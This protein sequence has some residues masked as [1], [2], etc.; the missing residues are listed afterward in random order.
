MPISTGIDFEALAQA[1][2]RRGKP[3][4]PR[5]DPAAAR[6][7]ERRRLEKR[8]AELKCEGIRLYEPM[9]LGEQFHACNALWR[10]AGGGNRACKSLSTA[11]EAARAL[12][13][14]DPYNKYPKLKCKAWFVGLKLDHIASMYRTLFQPGAFKIIRDEHTKQW[15]SVRWDRN[16]PTRLQEYDD[17]YR[18]KWRDAPPLIPARFIRG[19]SWETTNEVPRSIR[20]Q[21]WDTLWSSALGKPA[22]GDHFNLVV[23]DEEMPNPEF[24][25]EAHR[26]LTRLW[27]TAA[28]RPKGIWSATSQVAN[29]EL[30]ELREKAVNDPESDF[31]RAFTFLPADNPYLSPEARQELYDGFDEEQRLTR[32]FGIPAMSHRSVYP[33]FDPH[34]AN[35]VEPFQIPAEWSIWGVLDPG[36]THC[37]TIFIAIDPD[38]QYHTVYDG[39][40]L[41]HA[42]ADAWAEAVKERQHGTKF[43]GWIC[44]Q[45]RGK[46]RQDAEYSKTVA[47]QYWDA[48]VRA[49]VQVRSTGPGFGMG[50]FFPGSN[51]VDAREKSLQSMMAVRG[52]G[53]FVG[54]AKWRVM[55]GV[56]PELEKQ[57]RRAHTD[58]KNPEKRF[59]DKSQ[60]SDLVEAAEYGAAFDPGYREP[61]AIA[62]VEELNV[63]DIWKSEVSRA[64]RARNRRL[65][66]VA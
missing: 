30:A 34:G 26:G 33:R 29:P 63:Y 40:D 1:L 18:E 4:V 66:G 3:L 36:R 50:G 45:Q 64:K 51:D 22:Q 46:Q 11:A 42:D 28:Q 27:E 49:A 57:I 21:G 55:R 19:I 59:K 9:L 39:F 5:V 58:P 6:R 12:T 56:L 16:N 14:T 20:L 23:F 8:L 15:R 48:L 41:R 53:P 44:D 52:D 47:E 54:T 60:P 32:Y 10:L 13:G 38:Q 17:A 37:G 2:T 31:V 62:P 43:E 7:D 35:G 24:Y 61:E 65:S 25:N